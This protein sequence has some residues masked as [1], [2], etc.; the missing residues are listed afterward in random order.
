MLP[1]LPS[2]VP[3]DDRILKEPN[4]SDYRTDSG[5]PKLLDQVR[6]VMRRQHYSIRTEA[7]YTQWIVRFIGFHKMRHPQ[8]MD[9]PEIEAFLNHLAVNERVSASTQNQAFSAI[10]FLY[11]HVLN[12]SLSA[13]INALRAKTAR[14]LPTVLSRGE[15]QALLKVLPGTHQLLAR[16]LYGSGLRLMEGLRLR[17]KDVDFAQ[18]QIMVRAGKGDKDRVTIL[19]G[20]LRDPLTQHLKGVKDLHEKDLANGYGRVYLPYALERKYPNAN[21]EWGWQYVFPSYR[22][23][24]DPRSGQVRRHHLDGSGLRKAV[25]RAARQV[26]IYKPVGP[27]TL[28]Q[29]AAS[30]W[31]CFAT[32]LLEAG[33]DIRTIQ[34]LLG[35]KSVETTMIY[36]HVLNRGGLAVRSPLD[37]FSLS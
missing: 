15:I 12:K 34:E 22:L 17:V 16:L 3:F 20:A 14:R 35:H 18:H 8:E 24:V 36:T 1:Y 25:K 6:T 26:G 13:K 21:H 23:S 7:A 31:D 5:P 37:G 11:K 10:L 9:T 32:H 4:G 19:P 2:S 33:Y 30:P 29:C 27:H 28:R